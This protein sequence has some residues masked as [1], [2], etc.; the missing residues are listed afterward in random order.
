MLLQEEAELDRMQISL[1]HLDH[2]KIG[3]FETPGPIPYLRKS[4]SSV[5][6]WLQP[7]S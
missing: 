3:C 5:L 2:T 4:E 1:R 7:R 6:Q